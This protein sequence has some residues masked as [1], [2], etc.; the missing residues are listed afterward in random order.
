MWAR[1]DLKERAKFAFK[2][3][4]VISVIAGLIL[5]FSTGELFS[6][7]SS[8]RGT[9]SVG[10]AIATGGISDDLYALLTLIAGIA[11]IAVV[12]GIVINIFLLAPL[13]V[14]GYRFFIKNRIAPS[15]LNE[16]GFAFKNGYMNVV[17]TQFLTSVMIFLYTLLLIIPG[18]M[19]MYSY[20]L[21]P[22]I[23]A[24]NP[25]IEPFDA[26]K[27]SSEMMRGN[28]FDAFVLDLSFILW[29]ML[30]GITF[31]IAGVLYV[32]PYK[33]ATNAELYAVLKENAPYDY[34]GNSSY[35][36]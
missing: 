19:K 20:R 35:D 1:A 5:A 4:Y 13:A 3:N 17:K 27:L 16:F 22:Y 36:A 18:I 9:S 14:G 8:S 11:I 24:E 21:V 30:T 34:S 23:L 12:I 32:F 10:N 15:N 2:R 28:R 26:M 7:S 25:R 31:G 6:R 29:D 33:C